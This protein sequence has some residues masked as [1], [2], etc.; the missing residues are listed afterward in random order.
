MN[1]Q[2]NE[3]T[4]YCLPGNVIGSADPNAAGAV[5]EGAEGA[6]GEVADKAKGVTETLGLDLS[7]PLKYAEDGQ[8]TDKA[9][10]P[11]G[12]LADGDPKKLSEQKI[13]DIT[14][15]G[16]LLAEDGTVLGKVELPEDLEG[17]A[18]GAKDEAGEA[19]DEAKSPVNVLGLDLS[20]PLTYGEDGQVTD[21][22]GKPIGK[23]TEG[24][25]KKLAEQK[26]HDISPTGELL[27]EDGTVL[28]KIEL[29]EDLDKAAKEA[30]E[31]TKVDNSVL[32]GK[33][34]NKNSNV[35]DED[36]NVW[37][38][39]IE[40]DA[41]Q[42]AGRTV[43]E[44]G[45]VWNDSGKVIGRCEALP[46]DQRQIGG[47]APF[48]P[49]PD[50]KCQRNGDVVSEGAVVGKVVEGDLKK[51]EGH[52]VDADGDINDKNGN[53]IGKAERVEDEPEAEPEAPK[54]LSALAGK[55]VNKQGKLVDE[56]GSLFG[57]VVEGEL[58]RLVGKMSDKEGQIW[59]DSG[60]VIGKA[61][62]IPE[63]ERENQKDGPFSNYEGCKVQKD[64]TV[65]SSGGEIIG[66][67]T[68]GDAK[69]LAGYTVDEDG[70]IVDKNGNSLGKA[71]RWE[72]EEVSIRD[73]IERMFLADAPH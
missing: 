20:E 7:E 22:S 42:M 59:S 51:C 38:K 60:E 18:E 67:V 19:A 24:D 41:K 30:E 70:D 10:K 5:E 64:G 69:Q 4:I 48:E 40:G 68:Q 39:V 2:I 12:K 36:G 53:T 21:K 44:E 33:T 47:E 8:V 11:I 34:V 32:K 37:G 6:A 15:D 73:D 27:A 43:D 50:N 25:P 46:E 16:Q 52:T 17:A 62:L 63:S 72:P 31:G 65:V 56:H 49:F 71:E 14:P 58:K 13:S 23:L 28:G 35:V 1:T 57:T 66:R 9:G 55:R 54:D 3:L 26:I 29:P 61:D 45:Q